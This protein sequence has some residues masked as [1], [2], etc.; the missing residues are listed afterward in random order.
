[1][2]GFYAVLGAF[3][4]EEATRLARLGH[5]V[6]GHRGPDG[7]HDTSFLLANGMRVLLGHQRLSIIDLSEGGTQPMTSQSGRSTISYNGEIYNYVELARD[8]SVP[9][10]SSSDT[11]VLLE[12]AEA[13]GLDAALGEANGMWA[14]AFVR[15]DLATVEF[16]RDRAGKKPLYI[17]SGN[18]RLVVASE[19]K[20][21]AAL[22]G[23]R[24]RVNH[25]VLADY[26]DQGVMDGRDES[27]LSGISTL[28]AGSIGTVDWGSPSPTVTARRL[29]EPS[30]V[31]SSADFGSATETLR[32]LFQSSI[33]LRLRADVPVAVTLS[34][35]LDSSAIAAQMAREIGDP[36]RVH[37]I[38]AV[39]PGQQGD[40][41]RHIDTACK[42]LGLTS[43]RVDLGWSPQDSFDLMKHV[44][45]HNDAPLS[46]FS[47]IAFY[48]LMAEARKI[49][50]KVVL[51]GQ[52]ADEMFCG[53]RKY[54]FWALREDI[55]RRRVIPAI[56]NL[57]GSLISRTVVTQFSLGEAQRYLPGRYRAKSLLKPSVR[58]AGGHHAL[59]LGGGGVAARQLLD[60]QRFSVPYLT[61]YED[62]ASMANGVE[63]RLPF[64]DYRI[65]EFALRQPTGFKVRNG[66]T[67]YLMRKTFGDILPP[68]ILWRRD[69]QGFSN[70]QEQ[71]LRGEL[72]RDV[73]ATL[74]G[75]ANIY[76]HG[77][78]DR[79][80]MRTAW[81]HFQSGNQQVPHRQIFSA[82]ALE[83]WLDA[84]SQYI[85]A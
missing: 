75:D 52:G 66:W 54:F 67:K 14:L 46:S 76:T 25:A 74:F 6:Q 68:E 18:G 85:E 60:L 79:A 49:G 77:L 20:T 24:F 37:A 58:E 33:Q 2:C 83:T 4:A 11:E 50:I 39:S 69:K 22:S 81:D 5:A 65:M 28:P 7:V 30:L 63:V 35:G 70:P 42:A 71:W 38:S 16:A 23:T 40:E 55:A 64:L 59:G 15:H 21:V 84:F 43:H 13:R 53:Y 41:S 26:L 61:H 51:S 19:L 9:L 27:W 48:R 80:T 12:L 62:R 47:N 78:I 36:T 82:W 45:W 73:E 32:G 34:G 57:A 72:R 17:W 29:W 56:R 10:Q 44:T 1:M 31:E 8:V 3:S